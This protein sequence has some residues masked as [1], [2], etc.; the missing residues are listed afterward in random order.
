MANKAKRTR[1]RLIRVNIPA[2]LVVSMYAADKK[3]ADMLA[4]GI[5]GGGVAHRTMRGCLRTR[6]ATIFFSL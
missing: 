4:R 6:T 5:F 1:E 2:M 3:E